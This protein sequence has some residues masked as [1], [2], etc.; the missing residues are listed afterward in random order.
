MG[1]RNDSQSGDRNGNLTFMD[2]LI[3]D[4]DIIK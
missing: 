1:Y 4:Y 2:S 3:N